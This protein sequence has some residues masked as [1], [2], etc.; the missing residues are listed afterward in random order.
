MNQYGKNRLYGYVWKFILRTRHV[1]D[2]EFLRPVYSLA[3]ADLDI[4]SHLGKL[5]EELRGF[6]ELR[7]SLKAHQAVM[8]TNYDDMIL[9]STTWLPMLY[10]MIRIKRPAIVIE[11]GCATGTTASL[12]LYA[13]EQNGFGHL[14]TLDLRDPADWI[15]KADLPTGFL[16]PERLKARWSLMLKDAKVAL[17]ELLSQLGTVDFF[18]HDSDHSYIHQMWEILTAWPYLKSGGILASDDLADNTALFD[19]ARQVSSNMLVTSRQHNFGY[20]VR[21][22][23]MSSSV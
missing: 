6:S 12:I 5:N 10:Y 22:G 9:G 7:E 13:L 4:R 18:Y 1:G 21:D 14:Y 2:E 3:T 20:L 19:L 16:V 23:G 8:H 17:P 11:T 15:S